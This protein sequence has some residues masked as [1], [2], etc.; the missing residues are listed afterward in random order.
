MQI[1]TKS[2]NTTV[3][4]KHTTLIIVESL[5]KKKESP[6]K[7]CT[8]SITVYTPTQVLPKVIA[9]NLI[10]PNKVSAFFSFLILILLSLNGHSP[11]TISRIYKIIEQKTGN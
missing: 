1:K 4:K 7:N 2:I 10:N 6:K 5:E 11:P 8:I 9:L 3:F